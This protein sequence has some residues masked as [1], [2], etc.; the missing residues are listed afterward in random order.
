MYAIRS[1]YGRSYSGCISFF[2]FVGCNIGET[3][4]KFISLLK[5]LTSCDINRGAVLCKNHKVS[6]LYIVDVNG[7][8]RFADLIAK[9]Q[10]N[11]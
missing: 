7:N 6:L 5:K 11:D 10:S 1:Y 3:M 9:F 4:W 2:I 8:V